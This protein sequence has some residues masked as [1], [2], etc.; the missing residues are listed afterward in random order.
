T[1]E[2]A[3]VLDPWGR[4]AGLDGSYLGEFTMPPGFDMSAAGDTGPRPNRSL[5]GLTLLPDGR[6]LF[7]AMEDPRY[8]DGPNPDRDHAALVRITK[9]DDES[10]SPVAQY[11]YPLGLASSPYETNGLSDLVA[12]TDSSFLVVERSGSD[13][14]AVVRIY[15]ADIG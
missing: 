6:F 5:E 8:E 14:G 2:P 13:K 7:A 4:I 1:G 10:R 11:A 9:F 3:V 15:R 12:L